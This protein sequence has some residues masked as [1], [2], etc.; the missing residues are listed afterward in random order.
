MAQACER[1]NGRGRGGHGRGGQGDGHSCGRWNDNG[2]SHNV[3]AIGTDCDDGGQGTEMAGKGNAAGGGD[4]GAQHGWIGSWSI[5]SLTT[6][7]TD[8]V[9]LFYL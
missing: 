3:G 4:R 8:T 7:G 1:M 5:S 9:Y 6:W 2:G